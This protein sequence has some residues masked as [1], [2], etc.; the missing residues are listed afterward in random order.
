MNEILSQ[1]WREVHVQAGDGLLSE[2]H[3]ALQ[4]GTL[5]AAQVYATMAQAHYLAANVRAKQQT[6][7]TYTP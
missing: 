3:D 6:A 2:A 5:G 4:Q 1:A 7:V